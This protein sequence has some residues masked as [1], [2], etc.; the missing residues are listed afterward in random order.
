MKLITILFIFFYFF[1]NT[2]PSENT[3][4]WNKIIIQCENV[5]NCSEVASIQNQLKSFANKMSSGQNDHMTTQEAT[6]YSNNGDRWQNAISKFESFAKKCMQNESSQTNESSSCTSKPTI[7]EEE[8]LKIETEEKIE[9]LSESIG[10]MNFEGLM[11]T[12]TF[13]IE[14]AKKKCDDLNLG[15][16]NIVGKNQSGNFF[17][18]DQNNQPTIKVI[19]NLNYVK[20]VKSGKCEDTETDWWFK[21]YELTYSFENLN[22]SKMVNLDN[23]INY[24]LEN[25]VSLTPNPLNYRANESKKEKMLLNFGKLF[26]K[27][28]EKKESLIYSKIIYANFK[29]KE[30]IIST[31]ENEKCFTLPLSVANKP[32]I[33]CTIIDKEGFT[34]KLLFHRESPEIDDGNY[35]GFYHYKTQI[36]ITNNTGEKVKVS[37]PMIFYNHVNLDPFSKSFSS[38]NENWMTQWPG[39]T[40]LKE[41]FFM[42]PGEVLKTTNLEAQYFDFYRTVYPK[43]SKI[44]QQNGY[45]F[46]IIE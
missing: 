25:G 42:E 44:T 15:T 31:F 10:E 22:S 45:I 4:I 38:E 36:I 6:Y 3:R 32:I 23:N 20:N 28:A 33:E 41:E 21:E 14:E 1:G 26:F 24:Y 35:S 19:W 46:Q 8:K 11:N 17:I 30:P 12:E 40:V 5:S 9:K 29:D 37:K 16:E 13:V 7:S 39:K 43:I 34:M 27:K 2:Q 18:N